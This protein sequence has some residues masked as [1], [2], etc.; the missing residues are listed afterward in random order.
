MS[1]GR[2]TGIMVGTALLTAVLALSTV[3]AGSVLAEKEGVGE[4]REVFQLSVG[5]GPGQIGYEGTWR[6]TTKWGL[7]APGRS[8]CWPM[9]R[10]LFSMGRTRGFW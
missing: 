9:G 8:L 2:K 7:G 6:E 10:S 5:D 4:S 1:R 3:Y